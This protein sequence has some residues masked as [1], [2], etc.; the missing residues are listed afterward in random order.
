MK[1]IDSGHSKNCFHE[2]FRKIKQSGIKLQQI[3]LTKRVKNFG[4]NYGLKNT[5][6]TRIQFFVAAAQ[7]SKRK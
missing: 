5:T 4:S 7:D 2:I 1:D 3:D 6:L